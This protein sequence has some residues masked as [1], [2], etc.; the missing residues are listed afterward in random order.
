MGGF[1]V[2]SVALFK[3]WCSRY[4]KVF[5]DQTM[6]RQEVSLIF[7]MRGCP[8]LSSGIPATVHIHVF[9]AGVHV[10][11]LLVV[12]LFSMVANFLNLPKQ[13]AAGRPLSPATICHIVVP[14]LSAYYLILLIAWEKSK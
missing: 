11:G 2:V 12:A 1:V 3:R 7:W 6:G 8:K 13:F 14:R 10:T 9:A 5:Y 4:G